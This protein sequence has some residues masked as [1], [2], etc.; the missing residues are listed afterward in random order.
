MSNDNAGGCEDKTSFFDHCFLLVHF[1]ERWTWIEN[2][3][4]RTEAKNLEEVSIKKI[5]MK[6]NATFIKTWLIKG[7]AIHRGFTQI[8]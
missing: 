5:S 7:I 8:L 4:V 1:Q 6:L 2:Y 3:T